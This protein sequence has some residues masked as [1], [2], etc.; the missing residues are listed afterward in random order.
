MKIAFF[1]PILR[2]GGDVTNT[3]EIARELRKNNEIVFFNSEISKKYKTI[4]KIL[5]PLKFIKD[6]DYPL[7]NLFSPY[8]YLP[9][10]YKIFDSFDIIHSTT[11]R[12]NIL[13]QKVNFEY[14]IPFV[15]SVH[16]IPQIFYNFSQVKDVFARFFVFDWIRRAVN[17]ASIVIVPSKYV[18]DIIFKKFRV[19]SI[20]IP[21]GVDKDSFLQSPD[22]K[23]KG[24]LN[25]K[26]KKILLFVG[27][28]RHS[29]G[30][31]VLIKAFK[32]VK[33]DF[34]KL[35]LLIVGRIQKST[36]QYYQSLLKL[37]K[38][39][40]LQNSVRFLGSISNKTLKS[41][42]SITDIFILPSLKYEYQGI[43]L[44]EAM[45]SNI[46][47][48]ASKVEGIP[49]MINN[50]YNGLLFEKNNSNELASKIIT[51]LENKELR[52]E[53]VKNS[54]KLIELKYDWQKIAKKT[55]SIYKSLE[56]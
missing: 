13:A 34:S 32:K 12:M 21:N 26:N 51:L 45:A 5:F 23:M 8:F 7:L 17:N 27:Q 25:L 43:V 14:G 29:K 9:K 28:I 15:Y 52:K 55:Y 46:P 49:Y 54:N 22:L 42:Y 39:Y 40:K 2:Y 37:I 56:Q 35:K 41:L 20:I 6:I 33:K 47:V 1:S 38:E 11:P 48:I 18:Y 19:K 36:Y 10:Y 30:I 44:L 53:L 16:I 50:G 24:E 4:S 31:H 3:L